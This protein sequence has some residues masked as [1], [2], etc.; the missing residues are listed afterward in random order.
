MGRL[1]DILATANTTIGAV[2]VQ[3]G[4]PAELL[5]RAD[6]RR[7]AIPEQLCRHIASIARLDPSAI[8]SACRSIQRHVVPSARYRELVEASELDPLPPRPIL[9]DPFQPA[10]L[11]NVR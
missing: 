10:V 9:G 7:Q 3:L 5:V 11:T 1:V 4:V 6:S 2:A 8:L